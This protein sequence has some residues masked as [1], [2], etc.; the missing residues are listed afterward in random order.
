MRQPSYT[1]RTDISEN[2]MTSM[3]DVVFLLLIF[4]V[5]A[6]TGQ[7]EESLLPTDLP[8]GDTPAAV[9]SA[10][11]PPPVP[12]DQVWVYLTLGEQGQTVMSLNGTGYESF[13][14]LKK[15]LG[16]LAELQPENPVI[17]DI[18]PDVPA[19][20]MIRVYDTCR[21]ANFRSINFN[22]RPAGPKKETGRSS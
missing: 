16:A 8:A 11:V 7:I 14:A 12:V 22:A 15:V 10:D 13:A 4:F 2:M 6:A 20:E 1:S 17:L 3:I 9:A 5:C 18:A 21:A 19:G